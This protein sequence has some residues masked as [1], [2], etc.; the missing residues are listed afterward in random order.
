MCTALS[1]GCAFSDRIEALLD[2]RVRVEGVEL[3]I[4]LRQPQVLF[5]EVLKHQTYDLAEMS[6]GSHIVNVGAGVDDYAA[7][8]VFLSRSFRHSNIYVRSDRIQRPQDLRG[9]TIGLIDYRQTASIWVRGLLAD[10]YGV[11]RDSLSWISGG[12]NEPLLESRGGAAPDGVPCAETVESLDALIQRGEIDAIISP[13]EPN[14]AR[15]PASRVSR[16]F[17]DS[18]A[19]ESAYFTRTGIFPVMHCL[20][21]RRTLLEAHP[22]LTGALMKA[23]EN[24]LVFALKDLDRRDYPKVASPWLP[25]H[26]AMVRAALNC[27]PWTYGVEAN[28]AAISALLRYAHED[29]LTSKRLHPSDLFVPEVQHGPPVV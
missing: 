1:F 17:P 9:R 28:D 7:L 8:P 3:N 4:R 29:G 16:L 6:I 20:V 27:E 18:L 11:D 10:E 13:I 19:V 23:F 21:V 14:S 15:D 22:T 24:A 12:L 2:G 26:R 25:M 5:R